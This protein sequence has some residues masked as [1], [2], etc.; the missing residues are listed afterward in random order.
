M[1]RG[2]GK[3]ENYNLDYSRFNAFDQIDGEE[4]ASQNAPEKSEA[5][6]A[7]GPLPDI[8][9]MLRG[10]PPEL[11]EAYHLM[12]IAKENGD[13]VAQKKA[14][15]LALKAVEKGGPEVR[16]A[17]MK[18]LGEM[19]PELQGKLTKDMDPKQMLDGFRVEADKKEVEQ[20]GDMRID[21][22]RSQMLE[23]QKATRAELESLEQKQAELENIR[24]PEDFMKFMTEEG[25]SQEDLQRIF[26][27]DTDHMKATV[28]KSIAKDAKLPTSA[29][30]ALKKVDEIHSTLF[31]VETPDR[32]APEQTK[33]APPPRREPE[34]QEPE[35]IIPVYRLQYTKDEAGKYT[36]VELK[37]TLPGVADMSMISLDVSERHLRLST[38]DPA[39]RYAVNA[40]PFP[41]LIDPS[42]ARAKYSK[43]REELSISVPA[44]IY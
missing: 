27:G 28:D 14:N 35:V 15:E 36:F 39:P 22:L 20:D 30:V 44:K 19:M 12:S 41:V 2:P 7:G 33:E 40:G 9:D 25:I 32:E 17:F 29:E 11:R 13:D 37:C 18:N 6:A 16:N 23:G 43:K 34:S 10:A 8:R 1:P 5:D 4:E 24:N 21:T 42:G 3:K 38:V 31:G 26:S